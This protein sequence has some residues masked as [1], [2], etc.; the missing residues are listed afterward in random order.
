VPLPPDMREQLQRG[1]DVEL[2]LTSKAL[3]SAW[4]V[5]PENPLPNRNPHGC[6]VNHWY[7]VPA[8]LSATAPHDIAAPEGDFANK[9]SGGRF[10]TPF[11]NLD[12]PAEA[13]ERLLAE[14]VKETA[15]VAP[16]A[17]S[18]SVS[19]SLSPSWL[20]ETL[21]N[22]KPHP[23][24]ASATSTY[25]SWS[26][27]TLGGLSAVAEA[28]LADLGSHLARGLQP[29]RS[30]LPATVPAATP[31][32]VAVE[33]STSA[34]EMMKAEMMKAEMMKAEMKAE[35]QAEMKAEIQAAVE[36]EVKAKVR[37]EMAAAERKAEATAAEMA[38]EMMATAEVSKKTDNLP[39]AMGLEVNEGIPVACPPASAAATSS[40]PTDFT[41]GADSGAT[42][43]GG[44]PIDIE[45][46]GD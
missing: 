20:R 2:T 24:L 19:W 4:N 23:L 12:T 46:W 42:D 22:L 16:S 29:S 39:F 18:P 33:N 45:A 13:R 17:A 34:A 14:K 28:R 38:A 31:V 7:R 10:A 11:R 30:P 8:T 37:V 15:A 26:N 35:I 1:E 6:C 40:S 43:A 41:P 25:P 32:A 9:P 3:N 27:P 36:V 21:H 5:Q 44:A